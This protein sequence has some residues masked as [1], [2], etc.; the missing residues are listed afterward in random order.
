MRW[1]T[2][3]ILLTVTIAIGA[4]VALYEIKQPSPEFQRLRTSQVV[5]IP[6]DEVT[7]I[8]IQ[9]PKSQVVLSREGQTWQLGT[10]RV[11]ADGEFVQALLSETTSLMSERVLSGSPEQ[12]LELK[13]FGLD[14]PAA[15]LTLVAN[16][17][18]TT[19]L[20]GASTA[21]RENRYVQVEGRPEIFVVSSGLF[22]RL[23]QP[24]EVFRDPLLIRL[25]SW[26]TDE[27]T[28]TSV[29]GTLIL[30]RHDDDWRLT[31]PFTDRAD[32][33]EVG[34]FLSHL[35]GLRIK[36]FVDDAPTAE[37]L[38]TWG[39]DHPTLEVMLSEGEP[40]IQRTLV[41]GASVADD[42]SLVYAK[43]SDEPSLYAVASEDLQALRRDPH[44][45]RATTCFEFFTSQ[46]R[47]AELTTEGAGWTI[48]RAQDQWRATGSSAVLDAGQVERWLSQL[49]DLRLS[50][51]EDDAPTALSRYGLDPPSAIVAVWTMV[52]QEPQRLFVGATL[53]ESTNRYGRIEGR[54]AVVRLPA[55]IAELLGTTLDNLGPPDRTG[56]SKGRTEEA[57]PQGEST[58]DTP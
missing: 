23:D 45:L 43:R 53:P 17:T 1:K 38:S 46:V 19:L 36:R 56:S 25:E 13:A 27:L 16:T 54:D 40:R 51:F 29:D 9:G 32:R 47:K 39:L 31:Q 26:R 18:P 48:E 44:G 15:R 21:V 12:P 37:Q 2:T 50:G 35:S 34:A 14:P 22:D 24:A 10:P 58:V 49:A 28:V 11:R 3:F 57:S 8:T 33:A 42:A 4:Y 52:H 20:F 30:V 55:L 7:E 6:R 5:R 41:F